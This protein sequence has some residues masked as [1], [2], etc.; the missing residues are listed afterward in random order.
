[1]NESDILTE[2]RNTL[3]SLAEIDGTSERGSLL[4][5]L[6]LENQVRLSHP[7]AGMIHPF[8]VFILTNQ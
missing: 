6:E 7:N 1:M 2:A 3:D 8:I 4:A 5:R